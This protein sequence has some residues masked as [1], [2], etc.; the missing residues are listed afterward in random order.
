[1]VTDPAIISC[2]KIFINLQR[3]RA[4][5][6][7]RN[8]F[9]FM[10]SNLNSCANQKHRKTPLAQSR[11]MALIIP[12]IPSCISKLTTKWPNWSNG[13]CNAGE[14]VSKQCWQWRVDVWDTGGW[15]GCYKTGPRSTFKNNQLSIS[16][17]FLTAIQ[18]L[19]CFWI[20]HWLLLRIRCQS[21]TTYH[22]YL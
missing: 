1:M 5:Q 15:W 12:A 13:S 19:S 14:W 6:K 17:S 22:N 11:T 4:W 20:C 21:M 8:T 16:R 7:A 18:H 9:A 10:L 2:L 3:L